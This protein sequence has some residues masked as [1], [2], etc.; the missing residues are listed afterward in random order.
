MV[1]TGG[2]KEP[3]RAVKTFVVRTLPP[4]FDMAADQVGGVSNERDAAGVLNLRNALLEK[5]LPNAGTDE[6]LTGGL[7][8]CSFLNA[9]LLDVF[10]LLLSG[11]FPLY[12]WPR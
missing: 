9:A 12:Q 11:Q 10:P 2:E 6:S 1:S 5:P 7:R 4:R 8:N 3:V